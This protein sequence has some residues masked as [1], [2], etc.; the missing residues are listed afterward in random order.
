MTEKRKGM[1]TVAQAVA[2][3]L[4]G[5]PRPAPRNRRRDTPRPG[6]TFA[7]EDRRR[8][9]EEAPDYTPLLPPGHSGPAPRFVQRMIDPAAPIRRNEDG[10]VSTHLLA[11]GEADGRFFVFPTLQELS[12]GELTQVEDPRDAFRGGNVLFFRTREEAEEYAN[13]GW[14]LIAERMRLS[15]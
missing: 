11:S 2:N 12:P 9:R 13:G 1:S 6:I 14:K 5:P 8:R 7:M 10:S 15:R 3:A 4:V